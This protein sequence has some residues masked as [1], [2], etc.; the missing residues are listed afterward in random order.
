[1]SFKLSPGQEQDRV[2]NTPFL[3]ELLLELSQLFLALCK[4]STQVLL[5]S[6]VEGMELLLM[7]LVEG[8]KVLL[9]LIHLP[10]CLLALV[11]SC[12]EQQYIIC[13]WN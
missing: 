13:T 3:L 10:Q 5:M 7:S 4:Q 2:M 1:M 6:L 12:L 9:M 11:E 8:M